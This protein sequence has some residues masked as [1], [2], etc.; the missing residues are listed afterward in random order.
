MKIYLLYLFVTCSL[1][2]ACNN[3]PAE[4]NTKSTSE[5][6]TQEVKDEKSTAT[7]K[8]P[9]CFRY[10]GNR[11]SVYLQLSEVYG[12]M[13]GMLLV[14]NYQKDRNVGTL[15][16]KMAG[17]VLIANYTFKSEGMMSTRQV[18]FKKKGNDYIEGFGDV[19]EVN[20]KMIFKDP[21]NLKFD[22]TRI[23]VNVPCKN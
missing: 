4:K 5:S 6:P 11:D 2:T 10:F 1:L 8:E 12:T 22:E 7:G 21:A 20:G 13:T 17:D 16:G 23:F 3:K 15:E 14:K 18:A 19:S 9:V